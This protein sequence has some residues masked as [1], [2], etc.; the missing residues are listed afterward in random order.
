MMRERRFTPPAGAMAI[1]GL[2][3]VSGQAATVLAASGAEADLMPPESQRAMVEDYCL[4]CHNDEAKTAGLTLES[5]DPANAENNAEI[6]EK[7][8]HK[9]RAGMMPPSFAPRPEPEEVGA[10]AAALEAK[11]DA[12]YFADPKPGRRTFQRLNRAEY[13]QSVEDL[14]SLSVDVDALLPPDTIS[15]SFD[16]I[17]DVQVMSPTLM[18]S[19]LRAADNVSRLAVGDPTAGPSEVTYKVPH[20]A[21]QREH[22]DGTPFG[23]RGGISVVH[24]FP[25]DGDYVFRVEMQ[26]SPEGFLFGATAKSEQ[27]E[28]S[29]NESRVALL[30]VDPLMSE[31]DPNGL[32]IQTPPIA[33]KAG[34]Q[35][36]AAAFLKKDEAVIEDLVAPIEHTLAD[37]QIGVDYGVTTVPHLRDLGIGGPYHVTGVSDSA[38]RRRIFICRPTTAAEERPCA[39]EIVS[40]LATR[41]YRRPLDETDVESLMSFFEIG[42]EDGDFESGVRMALQAILTSPS[43][44]FRLEE[45]RHGVAAGSSYPI[46]DLDLASRLSFFLWSSPPDEELL[47]LAEAGKLSDEDTLRSQ[48][49]RMLKDPRSES[50][51]TRFGSLWLRLQDL[52]KLEPD[53][54]RFPAYDATLAQAMK[55][56]TQLFFYNLIEEDRSLLELLTADYTFVNERLAKHYEIPNVT[57]S[58]FRKVKL[59]GI[60]DNRIG[61]FGQGS[62]LALTSVANRTSPVQRGK[63]VMEVLLGSPPPPPPP[64]VPALEATSAVA[65]GKMLSVRQQ[66]ESHRSNPACQS[67]HAVIDPI[68]LALEIFDVTGAYRTRDRGVPI[69]ASGELYDGTTLDGPKGL[70]DALLRHKDAFIITFTERLLTY[71][72]G[73]R[74]EYTDMPVVRKIAH[75]ASNNDYHMSSFIMGVIDSMP[76]RMSTAEEALPI[77]TTA[78]SY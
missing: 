17:A 70:S 10:L 35:R 53:A 22:V 19:Y 73:R 57:G 37:S 50:L 74:V 18:D 24:N 4:M 13:K 58:E 40:N 46:T 31:T 63:W 47:K 76:F 7:M 65:G 66:M 39:Q 5:F 62:I 41:A 25:A 32:N 48:V 2:L 33:V 61:I 72:L 28:I 78:E 15:H 14:L 64:N 11:I 49:H 30:D 16:N 12:A 36:V 56:E 20:T 55:R 29:I 21:S 71:A 45:A 67:C 52:D 27:I 75:D 1:L 60:N 59:D 44:V 26:P 6:A 42:R 8:I 68:G 23:T 51:A 43:F 69:D 34:P 77:E 3:A 54:V 9:L 38:P